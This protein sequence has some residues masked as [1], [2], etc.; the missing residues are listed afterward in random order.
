M[1]AVRDAMRAFDREKKWTIV[2]QNKKE[3]KIEDPHQWAEEIEKKYD[4][5][6]TFL[7]LRPV[8]N[9]S[10]KQWMADF[11]NA[12]GL[13]NLLVAGRNLHLHHSE[14]NDILLPCLSCLNAFMNNEVGIEFLTKDEQAIK[15]MAIWFESKNVQVKTMVL[16][17]LSVLAFMG[18]SKN[19]LEAF[20]N[21]Q[22]DA[23]DAVNR[24]YS[25]VHF[26]K[27]EKDS[28]SRVII[29]ISIFTNLMLL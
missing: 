11:V 23:A 8:I 19:I 18:Q 25:V 1:P 17:L 12:G 15:D 14:N 9:S 7:Q 24:F 22:H 13:K 16:K 29:F 2:Q 20:K 5:A 28:D 27:Q 21:V 10:H 4:S 6:N 3:Q 26:L